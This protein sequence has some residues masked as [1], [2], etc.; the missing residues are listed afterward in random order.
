MMGLGMGSLFW[1]IFLSFLLAMAL[2]IVSSVLVTFDYANDYIERLESPHPRELVLDASRIVDE[3]GEAGL[4]A[5][6]T[7]VNKSSPFAVFVLSP[8]G[9]DLLGRR[10]PRPWRSRWQRPGGRRGPLPANVRPPRLIP[11]FVA[12]NGREYALILLPKP[13]GRL[14]GLFGGMSIRFTI[15]MVALVVSALVCFLLARYISTPIR[16]LRSATQALSS[17]ELSTRSQPSGAGTRRDELGLLERE[18]DRMA[19]RIQELLHS[20]QELLRNISHEFRTPLTRLQV[21]MD[22]AERRSGGEFSSEFDRIRREAANLDALIEQ[23]MQVSRLDSEHRGLASEPVDLDALLSEVVADARFETTEQSIRIGRVDAIEA[24]LDSR[25]MRSAIENV[26]RN[27]LHHA[28][29]HSAVEVSLVHERNKALLSVRDHGK[30]VPAADLEGIFEP[31]V[32]VD[33]ARDRSTGGY[34]LGLAI[35]RQVV[36]AHAGTISAENAEGGG[37]LVQFSLPVAPDG[38]LR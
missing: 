23:V 17:G 10:L 8:E 21:A 25:L 30:G 11:I 33:R 26:V 29:E 28:G 13:S 4:T 27:A 20:K 7:E 15:L 5:W 6:L 9:V 35:A 37:L 36:E 24:R 16:R 38:R 18:F 34:G 12:E 19:Q 2:I 32:R 14:L 22:L 3:S 31:F 1:K